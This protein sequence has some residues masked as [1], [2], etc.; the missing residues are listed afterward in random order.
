ASFARKDFEQAEKYFLSMSAP[1]LEWA[2]DAAFARGDCEKAVDRY[3]VA[4]DC[5]D[6][7]RDPAAWRS[8]RIKQANAQIHFAETSFSER[9]ASALRDA[10][11]VLRDCRAEL[12]SQADEER[13]QRAAVQNSLGLA[14]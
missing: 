6:R 14:L 4:L 13:V 8:I 2:G 9:S 1:G 12:G 5:V 3:A 10:V 7:T 11:D